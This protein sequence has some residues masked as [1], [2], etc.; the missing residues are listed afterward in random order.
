MQL[1]A[2]I[3][4]LLPLLAYQSNLGRAGGLGL[5]GL[6]GPRSERRWR[7]EFYSTSGPIEGLLVAESDMPF[8]VKRVRSARGD[9]A[10]LTSSTRAWMLPQFEMDVTAID[11]WASEVL[12][13]IFRS[14]R[15]RFV[16]GD[17][18]MVDAQQSDSD[19]AV[20]VRIR[21]VPHRG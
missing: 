20:P 7:L 17:E 2:L 18:A 10:L 3:A 9:V 6:V 15:V 11:P 14:H 8:P 12:H 16:S 13:G 19:A 5:L 4:V 21:A 1:S